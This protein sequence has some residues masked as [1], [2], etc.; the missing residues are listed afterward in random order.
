MMLRPGGYSVLNDPDNALPVEHDTFTCKHCQRVVRVKPMCD[1][2]EM[3]GRCTLCD[4]FICKHCVGKQCVPWE[5]QMEI[6]EA[7]AD[8]LR[9][10]GLG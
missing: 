8:A 4:A 5:R 2:V 6:H 1:P 9:S 10:Y 3:G 7:R